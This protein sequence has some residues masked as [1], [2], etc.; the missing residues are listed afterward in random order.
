MKLEE[1]RFEA[2]RKEREARVEIERKEKEAS[3]AKDRAMLEMMA[4]ILKQNK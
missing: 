1:A 3:I 4:E 2:N